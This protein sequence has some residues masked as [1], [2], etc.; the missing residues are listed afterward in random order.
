MLRPMIVLGISCF[1]HD[2]SACILRDGKIIAAAQEERFSRAKNDSSFP[3]GAIEFCLMRAGASLDEV[4]FVAFYEKPMVKFERVF[5]QH[6]FS[7]PNSFG[8]FK[9]TMPAWISERLQIPERLREMGF[10]GRV[11]F[12]GH[13]EAHLA[14]AYFPSPFW[15]SAILCADGAGEWATTTLAV[16]DGAEISLLKQISFPHSLGLFYGSVTSFLGFKV[17][18]G[19]GTV[20]AL[21]SFGKPVYSQQLEEI[22]GL[23]EDGSFRLDLQYFDFVAKERMFSKKFEEAF[24]AP[25]AE[26]KA[27]TQRHKDLAASL[28]GVTE[29]AIFNILNHLHGLCDMDNL[30]LSGGLAL[31]TVANGKILKNTPFKKVFVPCAPGDAGTCVGAAEL[32]YNALAKKP[33]RF[34]ETAF[35]GPEYS[36]SEIK[37]ALDGA[38]LA[39][40]EFNSKKKLLG[41]CARLLSDGKILGWFQGR[42]EFGPRAL[43]SRSIL[44]DPRGFKTK[45]Y[46]NAQVKGRALFRPFAMSILEENVGEFVDLSQSPSPELMGR[47]SFVCSIGREKKRS[48]PAVMHADGTSRVQAVSKGDGCFYGLISEFKAK[49]GLPLLLNTSFNLSGEP[50]V[51][52]PKDAVSAFSRSKI[53]YLCIGDYLVWK[54]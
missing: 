32:A 46:L 43:G 29:K 38:P 28:Q 54:K 42:M 17:N 47:M 23:K 18:E 37:P 5:A 35:L 41:A 15:E 26:G 19:E 53:D 25:R 36:N 34:E 2:S 33:V 7:F 21:A 9:K 3:S 44:A 10:K 31:N 40:E 8:A 24:G 27:I 14:S 22:L 45:D 39:F 48:I 49:T 12:A 1:Y 50:I 51:C 20:M 16:G 4:D 6:I 52:T 30:C 11:F 13:H